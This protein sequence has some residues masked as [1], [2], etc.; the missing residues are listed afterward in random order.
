[1]TPE[2]WRVIDELYAA[3]LALHGDE[4]ASLLSRA[5]PE[6]RRAVEAMLAQG[7]TSD[8]AILDGSGVGGGRAIH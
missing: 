4:R 1:M 8:Q 7:E 6:V 3:A 2:R 5:D